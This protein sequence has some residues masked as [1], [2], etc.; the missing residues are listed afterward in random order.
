MKQL[1][2]I[3]FIALS[4]QLTAQLTSK[5]IISQLNQRITLSNKQQ[6]DIE[7]LDIATAN[8]WEIEAKVYPLLSI[9]QLMILLDDELN[10]EA[11]RLALLAVQEIDFCK[12]ARKNQLDQLENL[13]TQQYFFSLLLSGMDEQLSG[14]KSALGDS[15]LYYRQRVDDYLFVNNLT[16][17]KYSQIFATGALLQL[18]NTQKEQ[19]VQAYRIRNEQLREIN[20]DGFFN[21][22]DYAAANQ[23]YSSALETILNAQQYDYYLELTSLPRVNEMTKYAMSELDQTSL[24][25]GQDRKKAERAIYNYY[26]TEEK[27][28]KRYEWDYDQRQQVKARLRETRPKILRQL[29]A[30]KKIEAQGK[31]YQGNFQW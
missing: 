23:Q 6:K 26:L 12:P 4:M 28:N 1:I 20:K 2:F 24:L 14:K 29:Q 10:R 22:L 3:L 9:E 11:G 5:E 15:V 8:F 19:I 25:E 17:A 7:K 21:S 30:A 27:A 31:H 18:S 13:L 16:D